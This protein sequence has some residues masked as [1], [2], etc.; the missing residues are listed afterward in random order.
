ML[1]RSAFILTLCG[2]AIN[3]ASAAFCEIQFYSEL[4]GCTP[5]TADKR[6]EKAY[7]ELDKC[8]AVPKV[9]GDCAG[10]DCSDAIEYSKWTWNSPTLTLS[11]YATADTTCTNTRIRSVTRTVGDCADTTKAYSCTDN[12]PLYQSTCNNYQGCKDSAGGLSCSCLGVFTT[13]SSTLCASTAAGNTCC[14]YVATTPRHWRLNSCTITT[15][16]AVVVSKIYAEN[17]NC[18]G[19]PELVL[20]YGAAH[21][22]EACARA[23]GYGVNEAIQ[24]ATCESTV[25]SLK[26]YTVAASVLN[27]AVNAAACTALAS[28]QPTASLTCTPVTRFG[29]DRFQKIVC[30]QPTTTPTTAPTTTPTSMPSTAPS[31]EPTQSPTAEPTVATES[32]T[33]Y[34]TPEIIVLSVALAASILGGI[35]CLGLV[36]LGICV[37]CWLLKWRKTGMPCCLRCLERKKYGSQTSAKSSKRKAEAML[38]KRIAQRAENGSIGMSRGGMGEKGKKERSVAGRANPMVVEM[39]KKKKKK[40]EPPAA[41][42]AAASAPLKVF[43]PGSVDA[44]DMSLQPGWEQHSV[45]DGSGRVYFHH[46]TSGRTSW[47]KPL[48]GDVATIAAEASALRLPE[49]W[50]EHVMD[51]GSGKTYYHHTERGETSWIHP[52][53]LEGVAKGWTAVE[54]PNEGGEGTTAKVYYHNAETGATSWEKPTE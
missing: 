31:T 45:S 52:M 39:T 30:L 28:T 35:C 44:D 23:S 10:G 40:G 42:S 29:R 4:S 2:G 34:D 18:A 13:L 36:I 33:Q 38:A 11:T 20:D 19:E 32:P 15:L 27:G 54:A 22:G 25:A 14:P 41:A 8:V 49:G 24:V 37:L 7:R 48:A 46:T 47:T 17:N 26:L 53:H 50:S 16:P 21:E 12:L 43:G 1:R 5:N 6:L 3:I 51:D 9:G